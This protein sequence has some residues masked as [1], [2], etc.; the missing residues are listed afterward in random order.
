[1]EK[2][3]QLREELLNI[4]HK[5]EASYWIDYIELERLNFMVL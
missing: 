4:G 5:G 2:C 1:M 3:R